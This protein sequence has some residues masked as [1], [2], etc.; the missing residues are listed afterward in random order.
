MKYRVTCPHCQSPRNTKLLRTKEVGYDQDK[1][2]FYLIC[3]NPSCEGFGKVRMV[4]KEGDSLGIEPIRERLGLESQVARKLIDLQGVPKV[5]LRNSI[6]VSEA[7]EFVDE[8]EIT[9]AYRY[10]L[11]GSEIKVVE[12][13][14]MIKDDDGIDSYSLLP[15][16]VAVALVKQVAQVLGL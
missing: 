16:P 5:F 9:P 1:K 10:E 2:E 11:D 13:P 7:K 12:E 6:P 4:T 3:D 8:Y 15:A 14:W